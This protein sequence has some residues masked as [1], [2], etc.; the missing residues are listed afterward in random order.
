MLGGASQETQ[1][2]RFYEVGIS[3]LSGIEGRKNFL[4]ETNSQEAHDVLGFL[5]YFYSFSRLH[6]E[7]GFISPA[8]ASWLP[9]LP[10]EG[11]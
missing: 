3:V 5:R 2:L 6:V 4:E 11:R 7:L 9:V 8:G 10:G 1:K